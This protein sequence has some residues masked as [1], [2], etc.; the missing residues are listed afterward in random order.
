M[1]LIWNLYVN[2]T[3]FYDNGDGFSGSVKVRE[4]CLGFVAQG[5]PA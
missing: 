1:V 5:G 3:G 4:D 2:F